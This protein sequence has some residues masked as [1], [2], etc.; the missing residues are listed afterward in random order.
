MQ[1]NERVE[2]VKLLEQAEGY[3][4]SPDSLRIDQLARRVGLKKIYDLIYRPLSGDAA[5]A[6]LGALQRHIEHDDSGKMELI[7]KPQEADLR[8]TVSYCISG[9]LLCLEATASIFH[10][11]DIQKIV[12]G[13]AAQQYALF[14]RLRNEA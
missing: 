2:L 5:H 13:R 14:D 12:D 6:T 1:E 10:R 8:Q 3:M 4:Q 9:I 11:D 7:F